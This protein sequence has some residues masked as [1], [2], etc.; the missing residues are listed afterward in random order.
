MVDPIHSLKVRPF[1]VSQYLKINWGNILKHIFSAF[2]A[3]SSLVLQSHAYATPPNWRSVDV[4]GFDVASV[5]LGMSYDEALTAIAKHFQLSAAEIKQTKASTIYTYSRITKDKQPNTLRFVKDKVTMEVTFSVRLPINQSSP[6]SVS[7]IHYGIP[8][9]KDN[10]VSLKE[11]A[12][13][14]YGQPSD[15]RRQGNLMW[16]AHYNQITQC[17]LTKPKLSLALGALVLDDPTLDELGKVYEQGLL[18]AKP[19]L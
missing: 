10:S 16:C 13:S 6:V 14:K 12:L 15:D 3:I 4:I 7:R 1:M 5:K 2:V 18:K 19:N 8:L 17:E 11:A 9:T